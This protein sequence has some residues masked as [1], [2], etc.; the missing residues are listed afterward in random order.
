MRHHNANRKLG[1]KS[2][3][4]KAL[5]KS[6]AYSLVLKGK[7]KTTE[8]KAKELRPFIEKLITMGKKQTPASK[9]LI[10]SRVGKIAAKK[11]VGSL[12]ETYK[13]RTGGYTR[14][15]KLVRRL[16][17]GAAMAVIEFV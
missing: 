3:P 14:I 8:P 1:R 12:S 17:D 2:G 7:I 16:T 9:R 4:R 5:L 6:L 13:N 10:E 11:I 15:T